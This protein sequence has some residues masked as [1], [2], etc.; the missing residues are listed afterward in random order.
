MIFA[1]SKFFLN[2]FFGDPRWPYRGSPMESPIISVW[3]HQSKGGV[4]NHFWY[5]GIGGHQWRDRGSPIILKFQN[6]LKSWVMDGYVKYWFETLFGSIWTSLWHLFTLHPP[7]TIKI[8]SWT[9]SFSSV[10]IHSR[11]SQYKRTYKMQ[12]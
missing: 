9:K 6:W 5:F 1:Y 4:T 3:G 11:R 7:L 8:R 2:I 10:Q 12:W